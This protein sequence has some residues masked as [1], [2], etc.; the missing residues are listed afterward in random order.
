LD[1]AEFSILTPYPGTPIYEHAKKDNLLV[2]RGLGANTQALEP[3]VK[4]EGVSSSKAE[5]ATAK[6]IPNLLPNTQKHLQLAQ[7]Q[8]THVHK[9]SPKSPNKLSQ[10]GNNVKENLNWQLKEQRK[11]KKRRRKSLKKDTQTWFA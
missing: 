2:N 8:T 6:G 10:N 11:P 9:V 3:T 5:I 4:I 1:Y 7:K